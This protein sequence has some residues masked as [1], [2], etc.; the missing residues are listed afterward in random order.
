MH[1]YTCTHDHGQVNRRQTKPLLHADGVLALHAHVHA[2]IHAC[3]LM[4]YMRA[5][6]AHA[7]GALQLFTVADIAQVFGALLPLR[8]LPARACNIRI[9]EA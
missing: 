7:W 4:K 9:L 6:E 5:L 2:I 3:L 1:A 8:N